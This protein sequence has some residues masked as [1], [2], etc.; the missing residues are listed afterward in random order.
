[1]PFDL[2]FP[3]SAFLTT[4]N[5][6]MMKKGLP[7]QPV[8]IIGFKTLP[9]AG[10][11]IVCV[12]NEEIGEEMAEK[13]AEVEGTESDRPDGPA[14]QA[15]ELHII[16]MRQ[17]DSPRMRRVL[18]RA[19]LDDEG[20]LVRIPIIVKADADGSLSAVRESLINLGEESKHNVVIDPILDGIGE[21]T[22]S[23]IQMAKES[24]AVIFA[25]GFK[26]I[27]QA[28]LNLA[29]QLDV[30]IEC[31]EIIYSL[32]DDAKDL[33]GSYLPKIPTEHVH[34]RGMV[35]AIFSV[36]TDSGEEKVAGMRVTEGNLYKAKG[37]ID[38]K[39]IQAYYRVMR[40]GTQ[41]SPDGEVVNASSLRHFKELVDSV[42]RGEECG[43]ALSGFSEFEEGDIIECYSIQMKDGTL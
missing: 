16:G 36:D 23:D 15:S 2:S 37:E 6:K 13:R 10:D 7:S 39:E 21:I 35:Q 29:E 20:G 33:F 3:P 26:R 9:K 12:E 30:K 22:T 11:P 18:D 25:F 8:R 38:S 19:N 43:L 17:R 5:D 32:L 28:T 41:V 1:M 31:N 24:D 4:V 27:D 34:G 14:A 42:R 40:D